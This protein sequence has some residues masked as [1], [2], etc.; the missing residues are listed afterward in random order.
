[1]AQTS[2]KS[3][4]PDHCWYDAPAAIAGFET[5][6]GKLELACQSIGPKGGAAADDKYYLPHFENI[7]PS[8]IESEFPLLLVT[9]K[10]SFTAG[11]YLPTPPFMNKLIPDSVLKGADAFIELHPDTAAK[12]A[13]SQGDLVSLKTTQGEAAVRVNISAAAHPG[14]FT[15]LWGWGTRPT[16]T[17]FRTRV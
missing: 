8:G 1:M 10:P 4:K 3:S 11:G 15:C 2:G 6:S 14:S 17:T 12:F 5:A 9:Y 16:T 7:N 13:F